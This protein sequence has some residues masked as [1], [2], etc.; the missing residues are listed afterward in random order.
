MGHSCG[1]SDRTLLKTLFEHKNCVSIKPYYHQ[2]PDGTDDYWDIVCNIARNISD[3]SLMRDRV[4][5]KEHCE[6]LS[7]LSQNPL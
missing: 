3:P 4:V 5:I 6:P 1:I 2:K 7:Q